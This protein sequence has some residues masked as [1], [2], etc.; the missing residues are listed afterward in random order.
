MDPSGEP[1]E[2][3]GASHPNGAPQ[4][5][6]QCDVK[7]RLTKEQH[8]V[9]EQHFQQ[10][11]KPSTLVKKDFATRLGVPLDKINNWFQNRRAK[12]KQDRK[13][14]ANQMNMALNAPYNGLYGGMPARNPQYPQHPDQLQLHM[15]M[16]QEYHPMNADISPAMLPVQGAESTSTLDLTSQISMQQPYDMQ[17]MRPIP[18]ANQSNAYAPNVVMNSFMA[19]ANGS[20]MHNPDMSVNTQQVDYPYDTTNFANSLSF[21]LPTDISNENAG[22]NSMFSAYGG[23]GGLPYVSDMNSNNSMPAEAHQSSASLSTHSSPFSGAPNNPTPQSSNGPTPPVASLVSAYTGW[24]E[25][26]SSGPQ[27]HVEEPEDQFTAPYNMSGGSLS[28]HTLPFWSQPGTNT[29][30]GHG[31][32]QQS[33]VS[34]QAVLSSPDN[35]M[36][37]KASTGPLDFDPPPMF[38]D[39]SYTRRNSS[40]S[41]LA[42]NFEAIQIRNGTPDEFKQPGQPTSIAQRRKGRPVTLNPGA[43][44]SASYSAPMPSPGGSSGDHTLRRIRSSGIPNVGGRVQK[45]QPGS[46]QRSPM[47]SNFSEAAASPK[48]ARAFSSSSTA[49]LGNGTGSLA[50]PT[51]L[52]PQ[53]M[54]LYWQNNTVIRPHSVMPEHNSPESMNANY[55]AE[56]Q[57]AGAFAKSVSPPNAS[58][59][60]QQMTQQYSS[61]GYRDSPPQSAP[62]TQQNFPRSMY[63]QQPHIRPGFHSTTDLTIAQP[64]PSHFRRPSLPDGAQPPVDDNSYFQNGNFDYNNYTGVSLTNIAHNVPFAP[65]P[66]QAPEFLVHEFIPPHGGSAQGHMYRQSNDSHSKNYIFANQGPRDFKS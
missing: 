38:Q 13:K 60:L 32:Y 10:Q 19:A 1:Q 55:S 63:M 25:D 12:V 15:A 24:T 61:D 35:D 31:F 45:S 64:K 39:D 48:F 29:N 28:E 41:N 30:Y 23:L 20:Y 18:E 50:P 26:P 42:G 5:A 54:G 47:V 27:D 11:H 33:N 43:M 6:P 36:S 16:N 37:R 9:L 3:G 66:S 7:P 17:A 22:P 56:S 49:T 53:D 52:T 8:D 40:T 2:A 14:I 44:R 58:L 62:A 4:K 21:D 46:A 65:R 34:S 57:S 59:E 51:P